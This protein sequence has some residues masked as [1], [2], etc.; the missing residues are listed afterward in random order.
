M[1]DIVIRLR[2]AEAIFIELKEAADEIVRLRREV[3]YLR[4]YGNKSCTAMADEALE[5]GDMD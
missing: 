1:T 3:E 2:Q 4:H 5:R